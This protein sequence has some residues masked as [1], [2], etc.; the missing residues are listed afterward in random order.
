MQTH[1]LLR[2]AST[3]AL[4]AD[5]ELPGWALERLA[6]VPWVVVRREVARAGFIP[7]GVRGPARSE[8]CAAWVPPASVSAS[9]T[10]LQLAARRGW[11]AHP[12]AAAL[13]ALRALDAVESIMSAAGLGACWGPAG[14]VGFELAS[15]SASAGPASDLD[16]IVQLCGVPA[17]AAAHALHMQL[18]QLEVRVDVLLEIPEGAIALSEYVAGRVPLLLRSAQGPRLVTSPGAATA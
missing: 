14:S 11:S 10:P 18:R 9:V 15:G 6:Q 13:P 8:R 1:T 3:A 16:V 2:L 12:R 7:V 5:E 17:R 4:S